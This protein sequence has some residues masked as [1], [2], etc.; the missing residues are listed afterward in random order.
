MSF[1]QVV[2]LL[3]VTDGDVVQPEKDYPFLDEVIGGG[4]VV[5]RKQSLCH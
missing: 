3:E 1:G 5:S 2:F 4:P